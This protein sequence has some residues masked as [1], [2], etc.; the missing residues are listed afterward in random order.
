M[1]RQPL[2]VIC[3]PTAS[4]KTALSIAIAKAIGSE[5]VSCDSMQIYKGMDI[6]TAKPTPEELS[7]AKH[8]LVDFLEPDQIFSVADYVQIAKQVVSDISQ[9]GMIPIL[10]GGTGLYINSLL[11]DISFDKT[12]SSSEIRDEL[13][14]LAQQKGNKYL[15]DMLSEFDP[16]SAQRLHENNLNRIIRAIEVYKTTGK[17]INQ[18]NLESKPEQSP[19]DAVV[20]GINYRDR[21]KLYERINI[22]VD[23]MLEQGLLDEAKEVI[24]NSSFKTSYQAIGHKELLPYFNGEKTLD[25]CVEVLKMQSRRYAKRQLTWFRRDSRINWIYADEYSSFDDIVSAALRIINASGII[26]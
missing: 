25:E 3:G 15:L 9:R 24:R 23:K 11:D 13:Y 17:T 14:D 19:Y 5:I 22:R 4:G 26:I 2:I 20:I 1:N 12:C 8:H 21:Q 18:F 7:Q 16:E 6:A 10:C